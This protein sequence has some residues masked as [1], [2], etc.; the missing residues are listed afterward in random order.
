VHRLRG[1]PFGLKQ[2]QD[3][4]GVADWSLSI[5]S[6]EVEVH[7]RASSDQRAGQP[8]GVQSLADPDRIVRLSKRDRR[9]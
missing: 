5:G 9:S 6:S 7:L 2:V 8:R 1:Y 4:Q 3:R